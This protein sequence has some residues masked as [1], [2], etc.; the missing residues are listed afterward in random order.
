MNKPT[1]HIY[2]GDKKGWPFDFESISDQNQ[3]QISWPKISIVTPSFNQGQ[4]IE[5]TIRSVLLQN[6]PNLE[7]IIIDGGSTDE[8]IS[9]LKKYD[10]WITYWVSEPDSGQS[11]A[12]NKGLAKCTGDIFNWINSDDHLEPNALHKVAEAF[13]NHPGALQICG[14]SRIYD[15]VT[16]NTI[17]HHRSELFESIEKTIVQEKINQQGLFYKLSIIREIGKVNPSLSY[18]MD[19]ELWFRFLCKYGQDKIILIDDVLANFRLH[20]KSKT[21]DFQAQFRQEAHCVFHRLLQQ[22][23]PK[24]PFLKYF[25][26]YPKYHPLIWDLGKI[27]SEAFIYHIAKR[28]FYDFY[29][30]KNYAACREA[31][32]SLLMNGNLPFNRHTVKIFLKSFFS[33]TKKNKC[34]KY[35]L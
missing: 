24:H 33:I 21:N 30:T 19:L 14:Y 15:D 25:E 31:F 16:N 29:R 32:P 1:I 3:S 5:Q 4:Y 27:N 35:Q 26:H 12:I 22:I 34:P 17:Q 2:Y 28:F 10:P 8:T 7:Y 18:V 13:M 20:P 6:Y 11:D 9:I 23:N